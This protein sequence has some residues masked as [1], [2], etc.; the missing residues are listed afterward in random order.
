MASA[1][2]GP[3]LTVVYVVSAVAVPAGAIHVSD[4]RQ[5]TSMA[6]CTRH[7]DMRAVETKFR[8][9]IVIKH[10]D[11]PLHRVVAYVTTIVKC[12]LVRIIVAVTVA[13]LASS[14]GKSLRLVAILTVVPGV[15]AQQRKVRQIMIKEHR[16]LPVD[17]GMAAF[18]L[19]AQR[20][21]VRIVI[22]VAGVASLRER[23]VKNRV[24]VAVVTGY[25]PVAAQ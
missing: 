25:F 20:A 5:R 11:G 19:R 24:G 17:L 2:I 4:A 16:V 22:Q 3:E 8:L 12:P 1:T 6:G 14:L 18:T 7:V 23:Y 21:L 13:A 9:S 10:P 15:I